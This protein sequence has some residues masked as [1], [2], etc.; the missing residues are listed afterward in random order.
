MVAP[1]Q[2]TPDKVASSC[3]FTWSPVLR[4]LS[5]GCRHWQKVPGRHPCASPQ[6]CRDPAPPAANS[7]TVPAAWGENSSPRQ[8]VSGGARSLR[9]SWVSA[10]L[11]MEASHLHLPSRTLL[12][13]GT[14]PM[15]RLPH[16]H[17]HADDSQLTDCKPRA[18]PA[19]RPFCSDPWVT[20]VSPRKCDPLACSQDACVL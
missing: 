8:C 13:A 15:R 14:L 17:L 10:Q 20:S 18:E 2:I 7:A 4:S 9:I 1:A 3:T 11:G 16:K 12:P 19:P 6:A 5:D